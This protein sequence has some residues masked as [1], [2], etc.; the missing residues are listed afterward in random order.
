[1]N[2]AS[3]S[4]FLA[5]V[6]AQAVHSTEE[7]STRLYDLLPPARFVSGLLSDDHRVGF[8]ISNVSLVAFGMWCYF[9]PLSRGTR[10]ALALAWFWVFLEVLNGFAH[11]VWAASAGGYRPGLATAPLLVVVALVLAR[12][13]TRSASANQTA[14]E[15]SR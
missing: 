1:M 3:R 7:Y 11:L 8:L 5:L 10:S 4:T 12:Q 6:I 13:L 15:R 14:V 9:G 2:R